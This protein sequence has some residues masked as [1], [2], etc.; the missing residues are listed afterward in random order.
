MDSSYSKLPETTASKQLSFR[1]ESSG[2]E[3]TDSATIA[4]FPQSQRD[5]RG[6]DDLQRSMPSPS[7]DPWEMS[8]D[9]KTK[10]RTDLNKLLSEFKEYEEELSQELPTHKFPVEPGSSTKGNP[11]SFRSS[12]H[13]DISPKP[14][15]H[16]VENKETGEDSVNPDQPLLEPVFPKSDPS[17]EDLKEP[18]QVTK[19]K[20][21]KALDKLTP[22]VVDDLRAQLRNLPVPPD[23]LA[24]ETAEKL[25]RLAAAG[26]EILD[27]FTV[28]DQG[29]LSFNC[30]SKKWAHLGWEGP[31]F[32]ISF[33]SAVINLSVFI[34]ESYENGVTNEAIT[35]TATALAA[36][37]SSGTMY[38]K[39]TVNIVEKIEQWNKERKEAGKSLPRASYE[40][41]M[42][43]LSEFQDPDVFVQRTIFAVITSFSVLLDAKNTTLGITKLSGSA[44][45][46]TIVGI[47]NGI[48]EALVPLTQL[49]ST[50][51]DIFGPLKSVWR[52]SMH[53][54]TQLYDKA[55]SFL[56]VAY[57]QSPE[58]VSRPRPR[59][60]RTEQSQT[61]DSGPSHQPYRPPYLD[62]SGSVL[63]RRGKLSPDELTAL[64][65]KE[66]PEKSQTARSDD[67]D[68]LPG[69]GKTAADHVQRSSTDIPEPDTFTIKTMRE[70]IAAMSPAER[71]KYGKECKEYLDNAN[72]ITTET[73]R[74]LNG[75]PAGSAESR[76]YAGYLFGFQ[77]AA[78]LVTGLFVS[79]VMS[80]PEKSGFY[81]DQLEQ[82]M[83]LISAAVNGTIDPDTFSRNMTEKLQAMELLNATTN[84]T[85][86]DFDGLKEKLTEAC[87]EI[88]FELSEFP[89]LDN[90]LNIASYSL[91]ALAL[92]QP[93][94][95]SFISAVDLFKIIPNWIGG[96][97]PTI[98]QVVSN[99]GAIGATAAYLTIIYGVKGGI[100]YVTGVEK[101]FGFDTS[102]FPPGTYALVTALGAIGAT[103]YGGAQSGMETLM[104][105]FE[106]RYLTERKVK[107]ASN[108]IPLEVKSHSPGH[109]PVDPSQ[110]A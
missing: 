29:K 75:L 20:V 74:I 32:G 12:L 21:T 13:V 22:K 107:M 110:M 69:L 108:D 98:K 11:D 63:R 85:E 92:Y 23:K 93:L 76:K 94:K 19:E 47:M 31:V 77:S 25:K 14:K 78:V 37:F 66:T 10:E 27:E 73:S 55:A 42:K 46:G 50:W 59:E 43:F 8:K 87:H 109:P 26:L 35:K 56:G 53:T 100:D 34:Y 45:I 86:L 5:V 7:V 41:V 101:E 16:H 83:N 9:E 62:D 67:S 90:A 105:R 103:L 39:G 80:V 97:K 89:A 81:K 30:C 4:H 102:M 84:G 68:Q 95:N 3:R 54:A 44:V 15:P 70:R 2:Q 58:E 99:L 36:A 51:D 61:D 57:N 1:P 6:V 104:Q 82:C 65:D 79:A 106:D 18:Q 72:K 24:S 17:T 88:G 49:Q 40:S 64:F 28:D 52:G 91:I 71:K 96:K 33:A 38:L 60:H 48:S